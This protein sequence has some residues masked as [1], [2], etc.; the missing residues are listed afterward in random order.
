VFGRRPKTL[1]E[2]GRGEQQ[3]RI[4][5]V[6]DTPQM[7]EMGVNEQDHVDPFHPSGVR[8]AN[9]NS[10]ELVSLSLPSINAAWAPELPAPKSTSSASCLAH[11]REA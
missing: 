7:V 10:V 2:F 8:A 5:G 6:T 4:L 11:S 1:N 9:E 3:R